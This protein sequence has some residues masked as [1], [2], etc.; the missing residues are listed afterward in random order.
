MQHI[1]FG[2]YGDNTIAVMQW[3]YVKGID[4]VTVLHVATG[5]GS[6]AWLER[7]EQGQQ[8]ARRYQFK[9]VTLTPAKTFSELVQERKTFPNLKYQW[10]P[11]FL[12]ALPLLDFL[13]QHDPQN[14]STII[15][16]SRRKDSRARFQLPEFIPESEYYGDRQVWHPLFDVST[17]GR[18]QLICDAGFEVLNQRSFECNPCVVKEYNDFSK[19]DPSVVAKIA[20]LENEI[21]QTLF[22]R[23]IVELVAEGKSG[24]SSLE[25]F[26]L[27]CGSRY[28]CGE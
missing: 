8:L 21:A 12:K 10:C 23:P 1:I 16:G 9:T 28:C 6:A 25:H 22:D 5:M 14:E 17:E 13:D 7:V 3:A 24:C 15:L 4:Q 26:D 19:L 11:T 18:D 2:N 20:I 27:G